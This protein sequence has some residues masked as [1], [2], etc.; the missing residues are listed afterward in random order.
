MLL[1]QLRIH[2]SNRVRQNVRLAR[3]GRW[4]FRSA[5]YAATCLAGPLALAEPISLQ[6]STVFSARLI[7]PNRAVIEARAGVKVRV[8]PNKS[9]HG[10]VA[11]IEGRADLAMISSALAQELELLRQLRPDL[12][13][14]RLV[15]VEIARTRVA[16][17]VHPDNPVRMLAL[18][19][20]RDILIG[21]IKRWSEVGGEA[22]DIIKVTVQPGGGVPTTVRSQLLDGKPFSALGLVQVE[23]SPHVIKIVAQEP[24]AIGVTQLG[25]VDGARVRELA[26]D[27]VIEQ[28]LNLVLLGVPNARQNA[29]I[30]VL[31]SIA[32]ERSF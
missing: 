1:E 23:A 11:L 8:I 31:K 14:G 28:Q 2:F 26:T 22:T 18:E 32:A 7:E 9:I 24:A 6:G 5:V 19:Q 20:I 13:L 30:E 17:A 3:C 12:P 4:S 27:R 29:L 25:L 15:C 16:F 10:L 21:D